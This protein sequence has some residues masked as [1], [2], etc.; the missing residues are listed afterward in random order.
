MTHDVWPLVF[1]LW[2]LMCGLAFGL[3]S[4]SASAGRAKR[5]QFEPC[6]QPKVPLEPRQNLKKITK[7]LNFLR[8]ILGAILEAPKA[9]QCLSLS[10]LGYS[11][12]LSQRPWALPHAESTTM[13][14][15]SVTALNSLRGAPG[16]ASE[17]PKCSAEDS[18]GAL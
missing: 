10:F 12:R 8:L 13:V 15:E 4:A 2:P 14:D 18:R 7:K 17:A 11:W 1:G 5:F 3:A 16:V 9:P 6:R